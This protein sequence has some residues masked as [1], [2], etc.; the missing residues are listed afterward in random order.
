MTKTST[1]S[2]TTTT[3]TAAAAAPAGGPPKI[4]FLSRR[5]LQPIITGLTTLGI[6]VW[7]SRVLEAPGRTSG[8]V[9]RVPVNLL[10]V[11][12]HDYLVAPRGHTN[13]VRNVRANEG[14]LTLVLGRRR[15]P[16]QATELADADKEPVL[17]AYL[18]RWKFEVGMFFDGVDAESSP[19]ELARIAPNH[20]V[21]ALAPLH[22]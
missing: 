2:T 14:G 12:G 1:L 22:R 6:S 16:Y 19:A 4:D 5:I 9:R 13:W 21:F 10:T 8:I 11:D 20:P 7:G 3:T 15:T 17:R 18:A